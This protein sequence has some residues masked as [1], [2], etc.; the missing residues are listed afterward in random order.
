MKS[1]ELVCFLEMT[2]VSHPAECMT[3]SRISALIEQGNDECMDRNPQFEL[4]TPDSVKDAPMKH[5]IVTFGD[6][7]RPSSENNTQ[8]WKYTHVGY[9]SLI[10]A[11]S[12][13]A[14]RM[15]YVVSPAR[16]AGT[17][18]R[19]KL[20]IICRFCTKMTTKPLR[21]GRGKLKC[22]HKL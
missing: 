12:E 1:L 11:L 5:K 22:V 2:N 14:V 21:Q 7:I 18:G 3:L 13:T 20:V 4:S 6:L 10:L 9:V 8:A 19:S 15:T 17:S 16:M